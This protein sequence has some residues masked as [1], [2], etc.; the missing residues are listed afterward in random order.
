MKKMLSI[1]GTLVLL[2]TAGIAL[3]LHT[4]ARN[5]SA[6]HNSEFAFFFDS[7]QVPGWWSAGSTNPRESISPAT[8]DEAMNG[9]VEKLPA[10]SISIHHGGPEDKASTDHCFV[11]ASYYPYLLDDVAAA[12]SEFREEQD[13]W[14]GRREHLASLQQTI[15]TPEGK[16][17]YELLRY[18]SVQ[19]N[20]S[21]EY[22][23]GYQI[24]F[25]SLTNGHLRIEGVCKTPDD[26]ALTLPVL[27]T[28]SLR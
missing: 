6:N 5:Q 10:A 22:L 18:R 13:S 19:P 28:L 21:R 3:F 23:S 15:S 25:V 20:D 26:L 16:K 11:M 2:C 27:P 1:G 12:Y 17:P 4:K 7:Q 8:Y 14:G 24:G 9:P